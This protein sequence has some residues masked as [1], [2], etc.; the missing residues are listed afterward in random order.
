MFTYNRCRGFRPER[1]V[2]G[3]PGFLRYS[4]GP[5]PYES[6]C[7]ANNDNPAPQYH[8]GDNLP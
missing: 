5:V 4:R 6:D 8:P 3:R 2:T 1:D 7:L